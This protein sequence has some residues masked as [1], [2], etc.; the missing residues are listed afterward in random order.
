MG[1]SL[2]SFLWMLGFMFGIELLIGGHR[3]D[4]ILYY[5]KKILQVSV[6]ITFMIVTFWRIVGII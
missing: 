5:C 6:F 2:D 1:T 4:R 3:E